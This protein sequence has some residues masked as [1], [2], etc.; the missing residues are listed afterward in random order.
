MS[1]HL[2]DRLRPQPGGAPLRLLPYVT[3]CFPDAA[4][5]E[6]LLQ[7]LGGIAEVAAIEIGF[8]FSDSIADG[9]VIQ[10]SFH[11]ALENGFK[12]DHAFVLAQRAR[13]HVSAA[14]VAMASYSLV[15]R[16][17]TTKFMRAAA[18]AGFDGV[19]LPDVPIEESEVTAGAAASAGLCHIGLIGPHTPIER[20]RRIAERSTGFVYRIAAAGTT[21]ERSELPATLA[22]DIAEL[23]RCTTV[24]ICVGFGVSN[25]EQV[26]GICA[27]A[28]GAIV[29]SAIVRRIAD[30]VRAG[31]SHAKLLDRVGEFVRALLP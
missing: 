26:R 22:A 18:D 21:G 12:V 9:P 16:Y 6:A 31:E 7:R 20:A 30:G 10:E 4:L 29:G 3:A 17:G 14:L 15:H 8:P 5:T 1:Q 23:R 25:R 19:I 27:V 2:V 13:P 24:P 28:D 11:A